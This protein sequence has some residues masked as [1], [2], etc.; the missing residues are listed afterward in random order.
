MA[1]G[2]EFSHHRQAN[3]FDVIP[4]LSRVGTR[5]EQGFEIQTYDLAH[6]QGPRRIVRWRVRDAEHPWVIGWDDSGIVVARGLPNS[7]TPV[8]VDP[9]TGA[10]SRIVNVPGRDLKAWSEALNGASSWEEKK[11]RT[12]VFRTE[13]GFFLWNPRSRQEEFLFALPAEHDGF[14]RWS[15]AGP[16]QVAAHRYAATIHRVWSAS[17]RQEADSARFIVETYVP[18]P[19]SESRTYVLSL[20]IEVPDT[21]G[22]AMAMHVPLAQRGLMLGPTATTMQLAVS[23]RQLR[24]LIRPY[25]RRVRPPAWWSPVF[26]DL[27]PAPASGSAPGPPPGL[28][29]DMASDGETSVTIPIR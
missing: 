5:I 11:H 17:T 13:E 28:V 29:W 7:E 22:P 21:L 10:V 26:V 18:H 14:P 12:H 8:R 1:V 25:R 16:T 19:G 23:N 4:P 27:R 3:V 9:V 24:D 15:V 2:I 6:R 20:G